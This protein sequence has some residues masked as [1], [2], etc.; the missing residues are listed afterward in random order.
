MKKGLISSI[1]D[2]VKKRRNLPPSFT[3]ALETV[4]TRVQ[5]NNLKS[6]HRGTTSPLFD[7]EPAVVST[8]IEMCRMR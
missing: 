3:M 6:F 5:R 1:I 2:D 4:R 8:I 7:I